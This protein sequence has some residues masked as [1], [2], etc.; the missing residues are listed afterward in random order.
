MSSSSNTKEG[1]I[2]PGLLLKNTLKNPS[3]IRIKSSKRKLFP[4]KK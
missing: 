3:I 1:Q 2:D 4:I